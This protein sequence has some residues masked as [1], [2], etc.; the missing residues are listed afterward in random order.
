MYQNVSLCFVFHHISPQGLQNGLAFAKV[1]TFNRE[2]CGL[3]WGKCNRLFV[4]Q[5]LKG[6]KY[7]ITNMYNFSSAWSK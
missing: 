1:D 2:T 4:K 3:Y 7:T 5:R 6:P